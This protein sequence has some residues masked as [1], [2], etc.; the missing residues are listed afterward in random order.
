MLHDLSLIIYSTLT[1]VCWEC[2]KPPDALPF[3]LETLIT[4][5]QHHGIA[6]YR[7]AVDFS[8]SLI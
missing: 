8:L 2:K 6:F 1:T 7:E 4:T 3:I 5:I